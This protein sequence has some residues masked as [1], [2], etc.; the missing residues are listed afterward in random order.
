MFTDPHLAPRAANT[1]SLTPLDPLARTLEAHGAKPGVAWRDDVWTY[2]QFGALVARMAGWLRA[3]GVG[4][5]GAMHVC[6]DRVDP[7]LILDTI[8]ARAVNHMCCAPVVLYMLVGHAGGPVP[9]RV[10]VGTGGAAPKPALLSDLEKLGFD[11]T[12]L[13]GLTES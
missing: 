2:A 5:A 4:A 3:Q 11:L 6:L 13:Y 10:K 7:Q 1:L 8:T 12:H 9:G